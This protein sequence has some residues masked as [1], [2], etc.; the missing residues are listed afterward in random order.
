MKC[1]EYNG[2]RFSVLW[3]SISTFQG[4]SHPDDAAFYDTSRKLELGVLTPS[5]TW[6]GQVIE[7]LGGELLVNNSI[8]GSTVCWHPLYEIPSYACSKKRTSSL[9]KDGILPDVIMVYMGTNDWGCGT[10]IHY[11]ERYDC[12]KETPALFSVAYRMMIERLKNNYPNAEIWC[13][14]CL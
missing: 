8:S 12:T 14:T 13:I 10:R 5:D 3:D 1:K 9:S 4:Y 2:K 11:D 7:W 6:W